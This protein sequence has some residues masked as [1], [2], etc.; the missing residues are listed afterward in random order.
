MSI[1]NSRFIEENGNWSFPRCGATGFPNQAAANNC[2]C[3]TGYS[4]GFHTGM[5]TCPACHGGGTVYGTSNM[6]P[7]C[8]GTGEV[9]AW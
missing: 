7:A 6:C 4:P 2:S 8:G 1:F 3:H 9:P 5:K